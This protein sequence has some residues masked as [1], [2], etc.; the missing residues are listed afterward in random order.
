MLRKPPYSAEAEQS[1]LGA[2]MLD[3]QAMSLIADRIDEGSFYSF[4]H[5]A[6]WCAISKLVRSGVQPDPISVHAE[7]RAADPEG[8]HGDLA[9]LTKLATCV[10]S[11]R[12]IRAYAE[13]VAE[14]A[15]ARALIAR[16]EDALTE[17]WKTGQPLADRVAFAADAVR[18]AEK[19]MGGAVTGRVALLDLTG[20]QKASEAVTWLC[21]GV[22][23]SDSIGMLF[24]GSGTFKTYLALDF[25]LHVCHGLPW[26][27]RRTRRGAVVYLAAEGGT[28]IWSRIYAWHRARA[29][30]WRAAQLRVVPMPLDLR[31]DAWKVTDA[32]QAAGFT[33][34]LVVVDTLS[35]T[36][37]GEENSASDM[38]AY[39]REIGTQFRAVWKCCV[40]LLHH[41]GHAATERPRGSSA[42]RANVDFLLGAFR[43]E[44]EMIATLTCI[45]QKDGEQFSDA[46]FRLSVQEL[47][48]D[49]D[50]DR[51]TQLVARHLSSREEVQEAMKADHAVGRGGRNHALLRLA[52]HN[53]LVADLRK[54][55]YAEI[56][57]DSAEARRQAFTRA[58]QWAKSAGFIAVEQ[59]FIVLR[60][61]AT[62]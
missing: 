59:G 32:V 28:G 57:L 22:V 60:D 12:N 58:M 21:K 25:A 47:G 26:M 27:G 30:D 8:E 13:I 5:R 52:R 56:D 41:S 3:A 20:L 1:V 36:F 4:E 31:A 15:A 50:G 43:D 49:A 54:A 37:A 10:P 39:L 40:M 45:K 62:P 34:E 42:I 2:L 17:A 16:L 6:I 48:H 19:A 53:M 24:G 9:Y 44:N 33:P 11:A 55:F 46:T 35:Q 14:R 51:I 23:P 61:Y 38:A 29:L 18:R 7:C